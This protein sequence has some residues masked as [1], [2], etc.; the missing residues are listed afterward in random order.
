MLAADCA[1]DLKFT[2]ATGFLTYGGMC[3]NESME[4]SLG[5]VEAFLDKQ[6]EDANA[7][8]AAAEDALINSGYPEGAVRGHGKE[9][10]RRELS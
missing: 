10:E 7:T 3:W 5:T 6:L 1:D 8:I 2:S 9:L 4:K